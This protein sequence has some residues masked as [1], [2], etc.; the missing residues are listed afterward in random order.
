MDF[1]CIFHF[2]G[3]LEFKASGFRS[4]PVILADLT[5]TRS[6]RIE[7][8]KQLEKCFQNIT[9][10]LNFRVY[11]GNA[12]QLNV[13]NNFTRKVNGR[14]PMYQIFR[15]LYY[16][17]CATTWLGLGNILR[18]GFDHWNHQKAWIKAFE[19]T[20]VSNWIISPAGKILK[21]FETPWVQG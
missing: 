10:V 12:I 3:P 14:I 9:S 1:E 13:Q 8:K 7:Q 18:N 15:G 5:I 21:L 17:E 20:Y 4:N 2:S 6:F 11:K 19:K 16:Q